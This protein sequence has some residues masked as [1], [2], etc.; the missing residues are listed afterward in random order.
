MLAYTIIYPSNV[1][2]SWT[3]TSF[4]SNNTYFRTLNLDEIRFDY[5]LIPNQEDDHQADI[6]PTQQERSGLRV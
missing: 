6:E 5:K 3:G 1:H 4:H 2:M